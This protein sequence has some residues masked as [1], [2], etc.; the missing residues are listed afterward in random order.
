MEDSAVQFLE[1]RRSSSQS[2]GSL[3]PELYKRRGSSIV[4]ESTSGRPTVCRIHLQLCYDFAKSDFVVSLLQ[5]EDLICA[6]ENLQFELI[7]DGYPNRESRRFTNTDDFSSEYFK[8]AIAYD[9]LLDRELNIRLIATTNNGLSRIA[10]A[11]ATIELRSLNPSGDIFVWTAMESCEDTE[12]LGELLIGIQYLSSVERLT[13]IA[14]EARNL[15]YVG[16]LDGC[17]RVNLIENGKVQKKRKSSVRR[18]SECPIWNEALAFKVPQDLIEIE[19]VVVDY[20]RIGNH[21]TIGK[22]LLGQKYSES[23][24]KHLASGQSIIPRWMP[25]KPA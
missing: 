14:H 3:Q 11:S 24:W 2:I 20:D 21:K 13:V 12:N 6:E 23:L 4:Q 1:R 7:I 8:Y 5:V 25:L 19:I 17:V 16:L 22:V 18:A 15:K 10:L 9:E